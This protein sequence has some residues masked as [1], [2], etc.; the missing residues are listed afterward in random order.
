MYSISSFLAVEEMRRGASPTAAAETAVSRI[1]EH[2]PHF[3]GAVVALA[4]DG[5][6]GAACHGIHQFPFVVH[7]LTQDTCR[8]EHVLCSWFIVTRFV[9]KIIIPI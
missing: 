4:K 1:A 6:Y 2:Y 7:D 9:L 8:T 3:M 5:R